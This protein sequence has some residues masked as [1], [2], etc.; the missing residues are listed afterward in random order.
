M[1]LYQ[2]VKNGVLMQ[3][4]IKPTVM[5]MMVKYNSIEGRNFL[6]IPHRYSLTMNIDWFEPFE[7]GVYLV[8]AIYLTVQNLPRKERYKPEMLALYQAPMNRS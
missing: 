7:R 6:N 2:I 8:G 3:H 5:C 1:I 4:L